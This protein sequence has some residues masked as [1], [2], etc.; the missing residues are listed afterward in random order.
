MIAHFSRIH[1]KD[2]QFFL[3]AA[4]PCPVILIVNYL[5]LYKYIAKTSFGTNIANYFRI[6]RPA[7][8]R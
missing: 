6:K 8:G 4:I 5:N 3:F 2:G 7:K 1:R